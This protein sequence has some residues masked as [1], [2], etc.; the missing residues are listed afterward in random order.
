MILQF[1]CFQS[2]RKVLVDPTIVPYEVFGAVLCICVV[3]FRFLSSPVKRTTNV[4]LSMF[5]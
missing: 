3:W 5:Q 2:L 1:V 4:F